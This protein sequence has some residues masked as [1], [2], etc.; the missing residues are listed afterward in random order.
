MMIKNKNNNEKNEDG[1]IP[2]RVE[3]VKTVEDT[4]PELPIIRGSMVKFTG[5]KSYSGLDIP[6]YSN[7]EYTVKEISNDRVVLA[8]H[9]E[10][11]AA[12]N[13]KDC[14]KL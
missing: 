9:G 14:V 13:I 5:T 3:S 4:K 1:I 6:Q 11:V 12:V 2:T 7:Q 8:T 10:I